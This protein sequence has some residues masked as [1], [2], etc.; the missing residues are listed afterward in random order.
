MGRVRVPV[1]DE[2]SPAE[3]AIVRGRRPSAAQR[4]G[5]RGAVLTRTDLR[6]LGWERRAIDAI[7]VELPVVV[8]PG[9]SRPVVRAEDYLELVERSVYRDDRVRSSRT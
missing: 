3:D 9:Y 1:A 6:E 8:L 7:F 4:L 2:P 5:T